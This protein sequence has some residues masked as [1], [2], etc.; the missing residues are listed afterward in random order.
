VANFSRINVLVNNAGV[1]RDGTLNG[2]TP[3]KFY[4]VFN[5]NLGLC[6]NMSLCVI[7]GMPD[8]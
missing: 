5:T 4:E 2:M 6:Y 7:S 3:T 8:R 1:T